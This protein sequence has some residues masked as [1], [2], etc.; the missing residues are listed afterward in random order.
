M[1]L[2]KETLKR[3]I[4]EELDA[5]VN[6]EELDE[7]LFDFI[8]GKKKEEPKEPEAK[9]PQGTPYTRAREQIILSDLVGGAMGNAAQIFMNVTDKHNLFNVKDEQE[10]HYFLKMFAKYANQKAAGKVRA[11]TE[12][13]YGRVKNPT[14]GGFGMM[15]INDPKFKA[16]NLKRLQ[17]AGGV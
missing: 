8:K 16:A 2:T 12:L 13:N 15:T 11:D 1:K 7:G 6:E 14:G 4:K 5:V 17:D 10:L 3:I 9:K